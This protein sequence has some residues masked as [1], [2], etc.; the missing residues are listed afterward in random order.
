[1]RAARLR[2]RTLTPL[3]ALGLLACDTAH[4]AAA[5]LGLD[6]QTA[7][8]VRARVLPTAAELAWQTLQWRDALADAV[9]E[10][11]A[12]DRPVLLWAMNGHPLGCT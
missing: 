6:P 5:D 8:A 10:A 12:V 1:M 9:L 3:L 2:R 7:E 11:D 4:S